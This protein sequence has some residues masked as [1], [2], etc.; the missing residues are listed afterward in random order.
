MSET[1][2]PENGISSF[3][4]T[5]IGLMLV[6]IAL[7]AGPWPPDYV[8][9]VAGQ[10]VSHQARLLGDDLPEG[11]TEVERRPNYTFFRVFDV[12]VYLAF[13][14]ALLATIAM[15][16]VARPLFLVLQ[17]LAGLYG[18][19]YAA[20]LGLV[21][22]PQIAFFGFA[23]IFCASGVVWITSLQEEEKDKDGTHSPA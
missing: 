11:F 2:E 14:Q 23:C 4:V 1:L 3:P 21:I 10:T 17:M 20:T 9:P 16:W 12:L 7:L 8:N 6:L 5:L 22:G 15:I 19:I 13:A 18:A